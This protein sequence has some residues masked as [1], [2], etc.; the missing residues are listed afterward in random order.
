[1]I[2]KEKK[3]K[4]EEE[5]KKE[6]TREERRRKNRTVET[7]RRKREKETID[8][9][10]KERKK[11]MNYM[12]KTERDEEEKIKTPFASP[13]LD[14]S[15][16]VI[17]LFL[18]RKKDFVLHERRNFSSRENPCAREVKWTIDEDEEDNF[19][20]FLSLLFVSLCTNICEEVVSERKE[21]KER[22]SS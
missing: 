11:R 16:F 17:F 12:R 22:R 13:I 21:T 20:L 18:P 14:L 4:K 10:R 15:S 8:G 5:K 3:E 19:S 1:M 7:K 6:K 2:S 9:E